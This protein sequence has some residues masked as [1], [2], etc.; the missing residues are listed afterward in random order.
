MKKTVLLSAI[1][2][3]IVM[4]GGD[5]APVEPVVAAPE[6]AVEESTGKVSGQ[7]RAFYLDRTY[8]GSIQNNRNSAAVGGWIGYDSAEWNGLSFGTKFYAVE[9]LK[10]HDE[11]AKVAGASQYDPALYGDGFE[12]Y[13]FIGEAYLNYHRGNTNLKV[14]RQRLD[15]PMAAAD[16][17]RMLPN[18]FE[19]AVLSNTDIDD[20]TLI[21][22]HVT[23][24]TVGTFGNVYG[25]LTDLSVQSGYGYGYKEGTNGRFADMG[26]IALGAGTDT[27]GVTA[28]A[29][30]YNGIENL[31]LQAWD[32]YAHDITNV[33]YLQADYGWNCLLN[34]D[35]KMKASAQY[36]NESDIGDQLA[37]DIDSNYWGVKLGAAYGALSG[38]VAY[39][40]TGESVGSAENGGILSPWGGMPAFTQG[41]V[42]RHQFFADT[43]SYKVAGT[44]NFKEMT[45]LDLKAS[46]YYTSFNVGANATY[47]AGLDSTE[48]GFDVIYQATS[49]LQLRFRGNFPDNFGETSNGTYDWDE[50]RFIVNYNF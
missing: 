20:T 44:Y 42:T 41:M 30:M 13:G 8:T 48:V 45:G 19:A 23:R 49:D 50:Y 12:N 29:V 46:A 17:A 33:L 3:T 6:A 4:A 32:Y 47:A 37:G 35:I 25:G 34:N 7:L 5:I 9:G 24:E 43:D 21:L 27:A 28:G 14:G 22:A 39:S 11:S 26:V 38:Y 10:I 36:I 31:K 1:A 18:L 40:Q 16:D 15:T 2:S